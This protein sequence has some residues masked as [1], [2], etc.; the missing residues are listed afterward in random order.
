[1][2]QLSILHNK[3]SIPLVSLAEQRFHSPSI[4]A[5]DDKNLTSTLYELIKLTYYKCGIK[6]NAEE[7]SMLVVAFKEELTDYRYI[8]IAELKKCFKSGYKEEYGKYYG[9]NVKTFIVWV[10]YYI[11]NERQIELNNRKKQKVTNDVQTKEEK[12][13][14][15]NKGV[16]TCFDYFVENS[17]IKDGYIYVYDILYEVGLLPVDKETKDK[18]YKSAI[19]VMNYELNSKKAISLSEKN[20]IKL[21]IER[22]KNPKDNLVINKCKEISL[23]RYFRGLLKDDGLTNEFKEQFK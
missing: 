21:T 3:V 9:L 19:E 7:L 16:L 1:M 14:W 5:L 2:T 20:D 8:T 10:E 22:I 18:V 4:K 23:L 17:T 15:I 11:K 13:Y 12:Q 6:T